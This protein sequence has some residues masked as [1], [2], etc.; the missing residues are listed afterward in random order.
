MIYCRRNDNRNGF[1]GYYQC[2][3]RKTTQNCQSLL[4]VEGI[5]G[6]ETVDVCEAREHT[7]GILPKKPPGRPPKRLLSPV[8]LT[9]EGLPQKKPVDAHE[10]A[11]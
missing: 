4:I 9:E 7:E 5:H 2:R 8:P 6:I 3:Q 10:Y 1:K 11:L